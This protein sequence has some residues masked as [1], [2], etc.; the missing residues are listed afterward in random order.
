MS[1]TDPIADLLTRIRNASKA[2]HKAVD[3]PASE[4]KREITRILK[5]Q[6]YIRDYIELPDAKQ[7]ILRVYLRYSRD[8]EPI[9]RGLRRLSRP[10]LRRYVSADEAFRY[11]VGRE[12]IMI[13]STSAGILTNQEAVEKKV[14]GEALCAVW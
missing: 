12:G 7:G 3:I 11:S 14:G 6:R 13:L 9:I 5:D 8:D 4:L 1:M 10:G 2:K